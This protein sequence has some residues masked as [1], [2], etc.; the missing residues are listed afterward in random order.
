MA[1]EEVEIRWKIGRAN[2]GSPELPKKLQFRV[3]VSETVVSGLTGEQIDRE[4]WEK[5]KDV[6]TEL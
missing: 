3:R 6:P 1:I 2:K 4:R 5:W